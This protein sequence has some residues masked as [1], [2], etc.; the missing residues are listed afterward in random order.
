MPVG[1]GGIESVSRGIGRIYVAPTG[2]QAL[3]F[4]WLAYPRPV[5]PSKGGFN[6][7]PSAP[8][9]TN[10]YAYAPGGTFNAPQVCLTSLCM[11]TINSVAPPHGPWRC[12][13]SAGRQS[14]RSGQVHP[15]R[16]AEPG[17]R[18]FFHCI[19]VSLLTLRLQSGLQQGGGLGLVK[20]GTLKLEDTNV[21]L[22]G[23]DMDKKLRQQAAATEAVRGSH[24]FG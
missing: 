7:P 5:N 15:E 17:S 22:I 4:S 13:S 20:P 9:A 21:A 2:A 11:A 12:R 23:S 1:D 6:H 19:P 14:A 8:Q 3:K 18:T 16:G 24:V 10:N